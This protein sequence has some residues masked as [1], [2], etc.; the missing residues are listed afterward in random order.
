MDNVT[1]TYAIHVVRSLLPAGAELEILEYPAP[2][3]AVLV[4]DLD[5]D[6]IPEVVGGYRANDVMHAMIVKYAYDRW[7]VAAHLRG[8]GYAIA[9]LMAAPIVDPARNTLLIGWQIGT[10]WAQLD[11]W[12][13]DPGGLVHLT[14]RDIFYS[15]L[16]VGDLPDARGPDGRCEIALWVHEA[17]DAYRVDL[18]RW[19]GGLLKY[20]EAYPNYYGKKVVPYYERLVSASPDSDVYKKYL[21]EA[22]KIAEGGAPF[23]DSV[24]ER[25]TPRQAPDTETDR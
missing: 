3:P 11:M 22:K 19:Q 2:H 14:P 20:A 5:G 7:V 4:A 18:W 24:N 16:E 25:G 23:A 12:Q 1:Q 13:A 6:G 10:V 9:N 21:R 15:K 17:G 8:P